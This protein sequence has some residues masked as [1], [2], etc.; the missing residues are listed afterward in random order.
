V[1]D[2]PI[3]VL[4]IT[5]TAGVGK[6]AIAKEI[7][8]LLRLDGCQHAV[9]DLDAIARCDVDPPVPGFFGAAL[10]IDN[11]RAI[12]PNYARYGV[13]TVVLARAVFD[14]AELD[15]V[16][17]AIPGSCW[18]VVRLSAPQAVV[19]DRLT[20]REPGIARDFLVRISGELARNA[21]D[22]DVAEIADLVVD[23]GPRHLTD[24]AREVLGCWRSAVGRAPSI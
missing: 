2:E 19:V 4:L 8:E 22:A 10:M 16:R 1:N 13:R 6:T 3:Q 14:A 9:I 18:F 12:W 21:D 20:A 23:N 5:G 7:G 11:L 17:A 24:V 15:D